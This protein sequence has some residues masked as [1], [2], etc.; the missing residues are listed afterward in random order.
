MHLRTR[1]LLGLTAILIVLTPC[2]MVALFVTP[3]PLAEETI[4]LYKRA[5]NTWGRLLETG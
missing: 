4:R 2:V 1:A 5:F 3:A